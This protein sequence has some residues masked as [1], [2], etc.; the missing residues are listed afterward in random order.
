MELSDL[1]PKEKVIIAKFR[2]YPKLFAM[3]KQIIEE[4]NFK[5]EGEEKIN[6]FV[7]NIFE[8]LD[9]FSEA[10]LRED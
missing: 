5:L 7:N 3:V 6:D 1:K 2:E 10:N 4:Y 8:N 9:E